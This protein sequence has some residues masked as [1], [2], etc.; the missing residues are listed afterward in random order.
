MDSSSSLK[1]ENEAQPKDKMRSYSVLNTLFHETRQEIE[2][3]NKQICVKDNIIADLKSRVGRHER[4]CM[5]MGDDERVFLG[6]SKS[7]VESLLKELCKIKQKKDDL[8]LKASC[9]AEEIQR[10]N[11][12]LREKDL[13][14]ESIRCQ[15]DHDKDQEIHRLRS[16]LEEKQRAEATRTVL[17][18]SLAEE[19]DQL[20][21]QLSATV[22]VCQELLGRLEKKGGDGEEVEEVSQQQKTPSSS[23]L[24]AA[25]SQIHQLQEENQQL[26]QRVAYVQS[27]NSQWQKYDSSREDYIRGLCQRLKEN[28]GQGSVSSVLLH[29]EIARLN[30]LL[31]EKIRDCSRLEREVE[32]IRRQGQERIQ[33]LEQ[34]VLIYTDDFKSERAD[35]ARAQGQ[36]ADLK[37]Q[38]SQL[39]QQIHK[40]GAGRDLGSVCRVHIGHRISSRRSKDS[41]EPLLRAAAERPP[42]PAVDAAAANVTNW[43]EL[44]GLSEL[45]CPH[46]SARFNDTEAAECMNHFEECA[47]L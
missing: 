38:I 6:P 8:E 47:R 24:S 30:T 37:E 11:L 12:Q 18:T 22:R 5:T 33:T 32:E 43:N 2:L 16:A 9:Q 13:E 21:G 28:T 42:P 3:L 1:A 41:S 20:R 4:I 31:E 39:K 36:I 23:D 25:K 26:K 46:C 35:R 27:L 14:L 7:L 10:L 40:Q 17:C 15:P 44:P 45:Q 19:A 29:Q 34:Q